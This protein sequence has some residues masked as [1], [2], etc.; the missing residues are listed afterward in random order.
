MSLFLAMMLAGIIRQKIAGIGQPFLM[1]V[2]ISMGLAAN[3]IP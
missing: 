2:A 3:R 1:R